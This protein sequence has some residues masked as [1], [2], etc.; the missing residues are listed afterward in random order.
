MEP[1]ENKRQ[2]ISIAKIVAPHGIKGEVKAEIMTDFPERF[3]HLTQIWMEINGTIAT[4]PVKSIRFHKGQVL[5]QLTDIRRR[6]QAE[7]IRNALILIPEEELHPLSEGQ[8]YTFQLLDCRVNTTEGELLGVVQE[9]IQAPANDVLVVKKDP[10]EKAE[11]LIPFLKKLFPIMDLENK[12]LT[13]IK[14]GSW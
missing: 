4:Y 11:I 2:F 3:P 14:D 13:V 7:A 8:F 10:E 6:E 5:L 1:K 12:N 9:V